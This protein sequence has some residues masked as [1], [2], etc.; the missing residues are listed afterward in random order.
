MVNWW[1]FLNT[2][3]GYITAGVNQSVNSSST[4]LL[5]PP[6]SGSTF[7]FISTQ[8]GFLQTQQEQRAWQWLQVA[9][10]C[11]NIWS[12]HA[13]LPFLTW[14]LPYHTYWALWK[15]LDWLSK[16]VR[17]LSSCFL[18]WRSRL[19]TTTKPVSGTKI[20][21]FQMS[22]LFYSPTSIHFKFFHHSSWP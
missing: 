3:W 4:E 17:C 9:T 18:S 20:Y 15:T 11:P 21:I 5:F 8:W 12:S 6:I 7:S 14:Y 1:H 13:H 22:G 10:R 2:I 16:S 19:E